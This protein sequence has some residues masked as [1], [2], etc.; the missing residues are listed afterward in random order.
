MGGG[1]DALPVDC[2]LAASLDGLY[3]DENQVRD[4][5]LE[6]QEQPKWKRLKLSHVVEG[7]VEVLTKQV[8]TTLQRILQLEKET[9][10][11]VLDGPA[12]GL[13][14]RRYHMTLY[15]LILDISK[16]IYYNLEGNM[17]VTQDSLAKMLFDSNVE[18]AV[19][20][21]PRPRFVWP[22]PMNPG[23][24][25]L[26]PCHPKEFVDIVRNDNSVHTAQQQLDTMLLRKLVR[27]LVRVLCPSEAAIRMNLVRNRHH[28]AAHDL[29]A[30]DEHDGCVTGGI[31]DDEDNDHDVLLARYHRT[32]EAA[33]QALVDIVAAL[34][35]EAGAAIEREIH[36]FVKKGD[37]SLIPLPDPSDASFRV[38]EP[39]PVDIEAVTKYADTCNID[40]LLALKAKVVE[41]AEEHKNHNHKIHDNNNNNNDKNNNNNNKEELV[42][43]LGE[44]ERAVAETKKAKIDALWIDTLILWRRRRKRL[45]YVMDR[46]GVLWAAP[47]AV[48]AQPN[49]RRKHS[50]LA[51][52][53]SVFAA[54]EL[55]FSTDKD[56]D[57]ADFRASSRR[58][59]AGPGQLVAGEIE[60]EAYWLI[61]INNGS[62]HYRPDTQELHL[63]KQR[64]E[65]ETIDTMRA[66]LKNM[67][68]LGAPVPVPTSAAAFDSLGLVGNKSSSSSSSISPLDGGEE[69][70][71]ED[72]EA[73][74]NRA[75]AYAGEE[76]E[77]DLV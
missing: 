56:Y 35:D 63:V 44:L 3:L 68:E 23:R 45:N 58:I 6:F 18:H 52:G 72:S 34:G 60:A 11:P 42:R 77:E 16:L 15:D 24:L 76:D 41:A 73:A 10:K 22:N 66:Q 49:T 53:A 27:N 48:D 57:E 75:R 28:Q 20:T 30:E 61:E 12:R 13:V 33:A 70:E 37:R 29:V 69:D 26:R 43:L 32:R 8:S 71:D 5:I 25:H 67:R 64:L 47:E 36:R 39:F 21:Q 2:R 31:D 4:A 65:S 19:L 40:L 55:V 7:D 74:L 38:S 62:G 9:K 50:Q 51:E 14:R 59:G 46:N 17:E 54:G 1:A